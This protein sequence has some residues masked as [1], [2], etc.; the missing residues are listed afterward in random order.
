MEKSNE[1]DSCPLLKQKSFYRKGLPGESYQEAKTK[2]NDWTTA[3]SMYYILKLCRLRNKLEKKVIKRKKEQAK[4]ITSPVIKVGH[5]IG[6]HNSLKYKIFLQRIFSEICQRN[7]RFPC[8]PRRK[9][10][11]PIQIFL[12]L[13]HHLYPFENFVRQMGEDDTTRSDPSYFQRRFSPQQNA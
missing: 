10:S 12:Y 6:V 4:K 13:F 5:G 2:D 3:I 1:S 7:Y 11:S 8:A 9:E